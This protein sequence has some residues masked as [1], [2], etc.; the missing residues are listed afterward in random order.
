[1]LFCSKAVSAVCLFW[2]IEEI[3]DDTLHKQWQNQ[4]FFGQFIDVKDIHGESNYFV[5]ENNNV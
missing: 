2:L 5:K 4:E 3:I 1:M